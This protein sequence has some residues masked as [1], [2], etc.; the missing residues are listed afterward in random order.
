MAAASVCRIS[1]G[2]DHRSDRQR[3]GYRRPSACGRKTTVWLTS[4]C[5]ASAARLAGKSQTRGRQGARPDGDRA[6]AAPPVRASVRH[7]ASSVRLSRR[8]IA[9]S[10]RS[11]GRSFSSSARSVGDITQSSHVAR[12]S[13]ILSVAPV[14]LFVDT[15]VWSPAF[16]RAPLR[17][18]T[19]TELP[20]GAAGDK[21]GGGHAAPLGPHTAEMQSTRKPIIGHP[22]HA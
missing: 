21:P 7:R 18:A 9:S 15:R 16:Q 17:R 10:V 6:R 19:R 1:I 13:A 2:S 22:V 4:G 11:T 14:S 12:R 20:R 5:Q 8:V 3:C